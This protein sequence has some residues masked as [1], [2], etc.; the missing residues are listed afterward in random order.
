[1]QAG[2]IRGVRYGND[3]VEFAANLGRSYLIDNVITSKIIQVRAFGGGPCGGDGGNPISAIIMRNLDFAKEV[4][5]W[6]SHTRRDCRK[7]GYSG[8]PDSAEIDIWLAQGVLHNTNYAFIC[9]GYERETGVELDSTRNPWWLSDRK[10]A[11]PQIGFSLNLKNCLS[12]RAM[13][14]AARIP[15][16]AQGEF[17]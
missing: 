10:F 4:K 16:K 17:K 6:L 1:M 7:G 3:A 15:H 2:V 9:H 5:N 12:E 13:R 11:H 14:I 8:Q